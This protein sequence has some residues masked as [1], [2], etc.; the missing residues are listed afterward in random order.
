MNPRP[1][2]WLA[3]GHE[4]VVRPYALTAGRTRAAGGSIDLVALVSAVGAGPV[5]NLRLRTL[6]NLDLSTSGCYGSAARAHRS[7]ISLPNSIFHSGWSEFS[8][9]TCGNVVS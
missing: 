4:R 6:V 2:D 9:P 7:L 8:S 1:A 3:N 5:P